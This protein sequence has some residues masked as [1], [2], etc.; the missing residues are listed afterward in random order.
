M[1]ITIMWCIGSSSTIPSRI[2]IGK[3]KYPEKNL[4]E[5]G[6][7]PRKNWLNRENK[8]EKKMIT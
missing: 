2:G 6:R 1:I 5:Q 3:Q 7:E 8:Y 4:S